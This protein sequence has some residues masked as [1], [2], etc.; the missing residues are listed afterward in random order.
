MNNLIQISYNS[1]EKN[2]FVIK[3]VP[4]GVSGVEQ[5]DEV[6]ESLKDQESSPGKEFG[7]NCPGRRNRKSTSVGTTTNDVEMIEIDCGKANDA[8]ERE[9][10]ERGHQIAKRKVSTGNDDN[11]SDLIMDSDDLAHSSKSRHTKCP[12]K[13]MV[14]SILLKFYC[15]SSPVRY[16]HDIVIYF[17]I[18]EFKLVQSKLFPNVHIIYIVKYCTCNV[19]E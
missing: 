1:S 4:K 18:I 12:G 15:Y 2:R 7:S 19:F 14:Y 13:V 5:D 17:I 11:S 3:A 16:K 6:K 8:E 9:S 10:A